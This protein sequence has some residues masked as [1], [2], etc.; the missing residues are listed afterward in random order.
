MSA[1]TIA[2][3]GWFSPA[4]G[5]RRF[6]LRAPRQLR[7]TGEGKVVIGLA[8]A[9]GGAAIN[10]GN[11]LLML[12]WGLVLS[13]IVISGLLSEGTLRPLRLVV[14]PPREARA[15]QVAAL[16][17]ALDSLARRLPSFGVEALVTLETP[18]GRDA[19]HTHYLLRIEP[20]QRGLHEIVG[21]IARTAYPFGFFEKS[22]RF[23]SRAV[24]WVFPYAV[25]TRHLASSLVSRFGE[26]S[27][28]RVGIGEDFFSLR[29]YRAG[30][31]LRRIHWRRSARVGRWFMREDEAKRGLEVMLELILGSVEEGRAEHAIATLGSLT[32]DLLGRGLRVGVRAPGVLLLPEGGMRQRAR[33]LMALARLDRGA[34]VPPLVAG[35]RLARVALAPA[36]GVVPEDAEVVIPVPEQET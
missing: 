28:H 4:R 17:V 25:D 18:A 23:E 12:G 15:R 6:W 22:R 24:F 16:P 33:A 3:A 32:E 20:G 13:A 35:R 2:K 27:A 8:F 30:D 21:A 26:E 10:T 14:R 36:P 29:P 1:R 11:N 31:D 7:F 9:V 5:W 34:A 19:A